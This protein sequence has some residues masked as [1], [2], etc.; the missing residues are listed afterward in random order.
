MKIYL[1]AA[2]LFLSLLA[3]AQ[4]KKSV[5]YRDP[6]LDSLVQRDIDKH[7]IDPGIQGYRIQVF[8]G[9]ERK[10]AMDVKAAITES[11]PDLDVYFIYQQPYFK[12]RVGDFR[13]PAEAQQILND[14]LA[15]FGKVFLVPDKINPPKLR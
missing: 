3:N 7:I 15:R 4:E 13:N 9:S 11:W 2:I 10:A 12:I 1:L 6:G 5:I 8:S 14:L